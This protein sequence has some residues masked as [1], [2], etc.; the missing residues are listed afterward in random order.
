[1]QFER[2]IIYRP[3][4]SNWYDTAQSLG[5]IILKKLMDAGERT[6]IICGVTGEKLGADDI[7]KKSIEI[8][9]ALTAAGIQRGD[10]VALVSENRF[11]FVFVLFGTIL[12]NC[13]L[14]PFNPSYR[15][16]ELVHVF[17]FSK[18]KFIFTGGSAANRIIE[19]GK[20]LSYVKRIICFDDYDGTVNELTVKISDFTKNLQNIN[21]EPMPV[22]ML[23]TNCLIFCSSGTSGLPKGVKFSQSN[24]ITTVGHFKEHIL[25]ESNVGDEEVVILGLLPLFHSFGASVL[26]SAM[27]NVS[28][29]IILLRKFESKTFLGCMEK[30]R[31]S[32]AFLVPPL[33]VFLAKNELVD[34]YDLSKL[35]IIFSGA[36][37]LSKEIQQSV[38]DRLKSSLIIKN[39]FGLTEATGIVLSQKDI[40]KPGSVGD[41]NTGLYAKVVNKKC[42]ALGPNQIGELCI[43]GSLVMMGYMNDVKATNSAIDNDGWLHTGDVSYYDQDLQFFIIDRI[44]EIIKWKGFQVSPSGWLNNLNQTLMYFNEKLI[45]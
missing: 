6:M 25:T 1:M 45:F 7:V 29:K 9:K 15:K 37:S 32:V 18:P 34:K 23:T 30:Y 11:E 43:K 19:I 17:R 3:K 8:A 40:V 44:K 42:D 28:G 10:I 13:T 24:L 21:F 41:I 39:V 38:K 12:I 26:I 36:A 20:K 33:M 16:S 27:V 4:I 31:C 5:H 2:N 22:D 35:K 14:V